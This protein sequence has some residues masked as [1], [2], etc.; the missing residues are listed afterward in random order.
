MKVKYAIQAGAYGSF[1]LSK[2][3]ITLGVEDW[4]VFFHELTHK[5]HSKI[6]T[7]KT[8]QDPEQ[9]AIAQLSAATLSRL[10]GKNA[11]NE[12]W[13]YIAHYADNKK[14]EDVGRLCLKVLNKTQ[15]VLELIL[16]ESESCVSKKEVMT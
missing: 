1:T 10:Y 5:A 6:E 14:P 11:D 13:N 2:N 15:K 3:T 12:S 8:E 16:S 4:D 7:L 9:E